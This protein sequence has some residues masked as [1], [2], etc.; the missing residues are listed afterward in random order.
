MLEWGERNS[1]W[2]YGTPKMFS[3]DLEKAEREVR[4]ERLFARFRSVSTY[5]RR[6]FFMRVHHSGRS[7]YRP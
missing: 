6:F 4:D 1:G 2:C 3:S 5:L 7:R